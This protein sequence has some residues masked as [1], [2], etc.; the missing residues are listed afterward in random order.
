M[1]T[2]TLSS[3]GPIVSGLVPR[4]L[5]RR[6]RWFFHSL[7]PPRLLAEQRTAPPPLLHRH[8][9][10]PVCHRPSALVAQTAGDGSTRE[11]DVKNVSRKTVQRVMQRMRDS[12]SGRA[13]DLSRPI[14]SRTPSI[15][16]IWDPSVTFGV[17]SLREGKG[18]AAAVGAA[19]AAP[20]AAGAASPASL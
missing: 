15:Q 8:S 14:A 12:A 9:A 1:P 11:V 6:A 16:G 5:T 2:S 3:L 17:F 10:V 19:G 7:G 13:R 18:P 4:E 20:S